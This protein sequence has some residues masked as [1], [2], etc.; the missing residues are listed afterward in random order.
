VRRKP[1][2]PKEV[3]EVLIELHLQLKASPNAPGEVKKR[4]VQEARAKVGP[5]GSEL[6][7]ALHDAH[8]PLNQ[9]IQNYTG[10][11]RVDNTIK[12]GSQDITQTAGG[13][14]T[15]VN[16]GG[17]QTIRDITIYKQDLDQTGATISAPIKQALIEAREGIEK[18]EIDAA[19]KP[20]LIENFDKL[21][22]ELKKGDAKNAAA[23]S[24]MWTMVY[25]VVK[26]VPA[27]VGAL[28][29]L[30]KLRVLLGY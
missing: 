10:D 25:S 14:M 12:P 9:I 20:I 30:D 8:I 6:A 7:L 21:T 18:S 22:N 4:W 23:A 16:A 26:A 19:L 5:R 3:C 11:N 24:G 2:V 29:A 1:D 13:D 17:I 27:A 15:G 28:V